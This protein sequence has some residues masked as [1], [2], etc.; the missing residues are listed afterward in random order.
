MAQR[1]VRAKQKIVTASIPYCVPSESE[2]T[3]RLGEVLAVLYLTFNEGHLAS[4]GASAERRNLAEDARWLTKL[5]VRLMPDEPE[6]IGLLALMEIQLARSSTR[7]DASGRLVLLQD[8]ERDRWDHAA[9]AEAA[10]MLERATA[11]RRPGPYQVQ[12]A[13]AAIHAEAASW[14]ATD[15]NQIV[16]LYDRLLTFWP[17]SVVRLNRA[18][19]LQYVA[20]PSIA[21]GEVDGLKKD[22]NDYRLFHA[23]R[24][25][26]LR[27]L[28]RPAEARAADERALELARNPA[29]RALIEERLA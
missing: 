9:I 15:W 14:I 20:G 2:M 21:L 17:T 25:Q 18:I 6:A 12:A 16:L 23:T 28:N 24:A 26:L 29:E 22:L 19:A 8:Q 5:L 3:E 13:I 10:A 4:D 27:A 11:L 1:I 7:F